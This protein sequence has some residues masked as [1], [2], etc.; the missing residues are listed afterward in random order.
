MKVK[1]SEAI[2]IA[3][4]EAGVSVATCVPGLGASEIFRDYCQ[5]QACEPVFSFHEEVAY[6]MAHGASLAG[7]R[8]FTTM[9]THGLLKAANSVSDSLFCGTQAGFVMVVVDDRLGIQSDSIADAAS[10]AK[11]IGIPFK[12]ADPGRVRG[13]ILEGFR[14]SEG[15]SLPYAIIIDAS[16]LISSSTVPDERTRGA[17]YGR[18]SG[19]RR[20]IAS[21]VLCP[22]FCRYQRDV[23][24]SKLSGKGASSIARP[25]IPDLSRALPQR[26]RRLADSYSHLFWILPE[27]KGE[28]CAGDTGIS[29]MFALPPFGSI[30]ATT[31]M[32]GS[33]PLALGA[34][35]AGV[36]PAWAVTGDFSFVAAGHLGLLEAA[37]R[38][39]PLKVLVLNNGKAETTGGQAVPRSILERVLAGYERNVVHIR[40]PSNREE[41]EMVMKREAASEEMSIVVADFI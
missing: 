35:M 39:I 38:G 29:T 15:L 32:G 4:Q 36:R 2:G 5:L 33:L 37:W 24:A 25:E 27:V 6:T 23:L 8:A 14:I 17:L 26:W 40:D 13:D 21:H 28:I 1:A 31:Y 20:D 7:A 16:D 30:D 22:P 11:G 34:Y 12:Q 9:K 10:L 3:L 41:V 18:I 19:H